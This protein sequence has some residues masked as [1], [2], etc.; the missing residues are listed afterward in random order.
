MHLGGEGETV[1]IDGASFGGYIKPANHRENRVDRRLA[2]H[3]TGKRQVVVDARGGR[4]HP[5]TAPAHSQP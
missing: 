5:A 4:V 3:Q 1:E 2:K